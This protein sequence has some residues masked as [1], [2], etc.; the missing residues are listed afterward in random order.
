MHAAYAG[1]R[2]DLGL[3]PLATRLRFLSPAAIAPE[4]ASPDPP[5]LIQEADEGWRRLA[6][7]H[8]DLFAMAESIHRD[9]LP[10]V[11]ALAATP[12]TF[13]A[14]DW[15]L[16]NLGTL[17]GGE[18]VLLNWAHPG[19]APFAWDLVWYLGCNRPRLPEPRE[20]AV[21]RYR[22]ALESA[23]VVAGGWWQTQLELCLL[24]LV[25][26]LG[27]ATATRERSELDWWAQAAE[28]AARRLD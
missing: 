19:E 20:V 6:D 24:G 8:P 27:W 9:P 21:Q 5:P 22:S 13:V 16:T 1:Y 18:T 14:G 28:R 15:R 26:S 4:L 12:Q 17:P 23:G 25:S 3:E 7:L 2:D 10:L 11:Q